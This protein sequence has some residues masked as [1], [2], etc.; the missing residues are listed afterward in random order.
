MSEYHYA[1][2]E[3][4]GAPEGVES[5]WAASSLMRFALM[6]QQAFAHLQHEGPWLVS[7]GD[8]AKTQLTSL[9]DDLGPQAVIGNLTSYLSGQEL[10]SHLSRSLVAQVPDGQTVLLRSYT[11]QVMPVLHERKDCSW[12][13]SLFGPI[14]EW[15]VELEGQCKRFEGGRL[16]ASPD[17]QAILLDDALLRRL[18][19]DPQALALLEELE[20]SASEV[21]TDT[22]HG[23]RLEQVGR[24]LNQARQSGL[25]H[26]DDQLLFA[27]LSL[28][29]GAPLD[30]KENWQQIRMS[31]LE[32]E[33]TLSEALET[34]MEPDFL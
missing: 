6:Q 27:T 17:Y 24:A 14:N 31:M 22:C 26:R 5:Y 34:N 9:Q 12:H 33:F 19:V 3:Q 10:A 2:V 25:R 32:N 28:M 1:I 18:A 11:P 4:P 30:A 13:A 7:L 29:E 20:A 8:D 15:W 23:E 16:K 21:F